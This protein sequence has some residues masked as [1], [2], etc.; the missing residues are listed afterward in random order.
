[1]KQERSFFYTGHSTEEAIRLLQEE[2][3]QEGSLI[4]YKREGISPYAAFQNIISLPD[5]Y[6]KILHKTKYKT[7]LYC[8]TVPIPGALLGNMQDMKQ[9][10]LD[11][12]KALLSL[13]T[14]ERV[15]IIYVP[16]EY[17]CFIKFFFVPLI[18]ND[19]I[20][21]INGTEMLKKNQTFKDPGYSSGC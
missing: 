7:P 21:K 12:S 10:Y 15:V 8:I 14:E 3:V 16:V 9:Y 18:K 11:C 4:L 13:Y 20:V 6:C 2:A 19:G 1:M 17:P 5:L